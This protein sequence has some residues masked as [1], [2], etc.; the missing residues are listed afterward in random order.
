[1][2]GESM[3][4][5]LALTLCLMSFFTYHCSAEVVIDTIPYSPCNLECTAWIYRTANDGVLYEPKVGLQLDLVH[6]GFTEGN[7]RITICGDGPDASS[8]SI[9]VGIDGEVVATIDLQVWALNHSR[10]SST[11]QGGGDAIVAIDRGEHMI[12]LWAREDG[13]VVTDVKF[14]RI[15]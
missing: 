4:K 10:C 13:L 14:E 7:Y 1:M 5:V 3:K 8:D 2:K 6:A 9:Y 15:D 12:N 11:L